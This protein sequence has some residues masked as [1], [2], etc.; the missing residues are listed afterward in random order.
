MSGV[1][2][3]LAASLAT[4]AV[5]A[6]GQVAAEN[7]A[8]DL[9]QRQIRQQSVQLRLQQNQEMIER[10]RKL[11]Q[12]LAA[13]QV[14]LA[15]RNIAPTSGSVRA[16]SLGNFRNFYEDE[17]ASQL[18]YAAKQLA[19]ARQSKLVTTMRNAQIFGTVTNLAAT[20]AS[21]YYDYYKIPGKSL[22]DTSKRLADQS[23][24]F[25]LNR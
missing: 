19:L 15:T 3:A 16:V 9:Q 5:S 22:V 7:E 4:S 14:S 25:N 23:S 6:V 17:H 24:P 2:I 13:E 20:T 8:E 12:V 10:Q 18:N 21:T 11:E 1:E